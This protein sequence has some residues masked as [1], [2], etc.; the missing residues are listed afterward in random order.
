MTVFS[1]CALREKGVGGMRGS[2]RY[3]ELAPMEYVGV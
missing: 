2:G 3:L 1:P